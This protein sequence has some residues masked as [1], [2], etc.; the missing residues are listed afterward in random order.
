MRLLTVLVLIAVL[1]LP[2]LAHAVETKTLS[3]GE[4]FS[5]EAE[6]NAT[7][8]F[9]WRFAH[10]LDETVLRLA[11][12]T[13]IPRNSPGPHMPVGA[14]GKEVW[15]FEAVGRGTT[16]ISLEYL[17]SWEKGIPPIRTMIV[18]VNVK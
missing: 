13:Y 15:T 14:G 4:K 1:F 2:Q 9:E 3:P 6:A 5:L 18:Q 16:E 7:T 10:P 12:T 8:G 17:R 11:D